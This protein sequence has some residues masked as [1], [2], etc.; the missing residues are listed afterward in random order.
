VEKSDGEYHSGEDAREKRM[1]LMGRASDLARR[2]TDAL[3]RFRWLMV[4]LNTDADEQHS[5]KRKV[6]YGHRESAEKA[7]LKMEEKL[8]RRMDAYPCDYCDGWHVG[9]ATW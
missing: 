7:A 4:E 1:R 2:V 9:S 3:Q 5:C 8:G 6:R